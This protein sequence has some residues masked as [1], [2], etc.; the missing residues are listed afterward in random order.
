MAAGNRG[1]NSVWASAAALAGRRKGALLF[2]P[3]DA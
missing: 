2:E 3:L 1:N